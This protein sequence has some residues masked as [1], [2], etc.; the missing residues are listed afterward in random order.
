MIEIAI[1]GHETLR[2]EH[3][4]LDFNGTLACDGMLLTGVSEALRI[5]AKELSVHVVTADIFGHAREALG[6]LHC[7]LAILP[8][9]N[10][11]AAKMEY[12]HKLGAA[13]C[14]CVG[15]G[16]N[17]RLMLASAALGIAVVQREGAAVETVMSAKVVCPDIVSAL[18][19][20][21]NPKRLIATLRD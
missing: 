15:N 19:L 3:L 5:L 20:L 1:P 6:D 18:E 12:V 2:L 13:A 8:P 4:V 7:Q 21:L 17:D 9:G 10:Q 14:A 11:A 16:R